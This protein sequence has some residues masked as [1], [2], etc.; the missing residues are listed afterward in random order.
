MNKH[1]DLVVVGG[2]FAGVAAAMEAARHGKQVLL[3]EKYNCLGGA[4]MNCLVMPFMNFWTHG[5]NLNYYVNYIY[6][7][8]AP[9]WGSTSDQILLED[10]ND[11]TIHLI[12]GAGSGSRFGVFTVNDLYKEF[13]QDTIRDEYTVQQGQKVKLTLYWTG[14]AGDYGT[15]YELRKNSP[16]YWINA[17]DAKSDITLWNPTEFG[18]EFVPPEDWEEGDVIP[19][20]M[21]TDNQGTVTIDTAGVEPGIYYLAAPGG[22]S[23]T[24]AMDANDKPS[25]AEAGAALFKLTVEPFAG[26]V[27]DVDGDLLISAKDATMILRAVA[28]KVTVDSGAAD[29]DSDGFVTAKDATMVLRYVAKKIESFPANNK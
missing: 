19:A 7:I 1:Y 15:S 10:G 13:S 28:N 29:V 12:T 18:A 21:Y 23:P 24:G 14:T 5:T 3:V 4:A 2:G 6:P 16:I 17:V 25:S 27:G 20:E 11:L 8:G 26:M 22:F 9:A